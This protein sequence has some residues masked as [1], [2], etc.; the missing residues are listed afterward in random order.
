MLDR[1]IDGIVQRRRPE[2]N[3]QLRILGGGDDHVLCV[4]DGGRKVVE[5]VV[6]AEDLVELAL[7]EVE[8]R[9]TEVGL[10]EVLELGDKPG[11]ANNESGSATGQGQMDRE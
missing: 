3:H 4:S 11:E 9:L 10:R 5:V 6:K 8:V 7:A 1:R 2:I